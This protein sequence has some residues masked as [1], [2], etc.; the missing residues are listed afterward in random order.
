MSTFRKD[1]GGLRAISVL[2][3]LLFHFK[4]PGF[5][6]G[7]VGVDVFFVISGYLMTQIIVGRMKEEKF[8][9]LGF[10]RARALRILP[11]LYLMLIALLVSGFFFMAPLD[12]RS[13][14][15]SATSAALFVSNIL[16]WG[17][18]GYFQGGSEENWLLHTWSLSVEWQFYMLYPIALL[19]ACKVGLKSRLPAAIAAALLLSWGVAIFLGGA[20]PSIGFFSLPSRCWELLAGG[21]CIYA[22][23]LQGLSARVTQALG[24]IIIACCVCLYR[25]F[26]SYPGFWAALPVTGACL[27]LCVRHDN[28]LLSNPLSQ[29]IGDISYS[30]YLWHWP[31]VAAARYF[32]IDVSG[33]NIAWLF[34]ASFVL[35]QGSYSLVERNMKGKTV[36]RLQVSTAS[37]LA[38]AA[39]LVIS[40]GQVIQLKE[41][42]LSR[43]PPQYRSLL[44]ENEILSS[45]WKYP[46]ECQTNF[47]KSFRNPDV[48]LKVCTFPKMRD[49]GLLFWGDSLIEQLYPAVMEIAANSSESTGFKMVTSGGCLPVRRLNRTSE[50]YYCHEFNERVFQMALKKGARPV[51]V[52]LGGSWLRQLLGSQGVGPFVCEV[53][54]TSCREFSSREDAMAFVHDQLIRDIRE[55]K[56]A[57]VEVVIVLPF[58]VQPVDVAK[59]L[60][61]RLFLGLEERILVR[62]E[63]FENMSRPVTSMLIDVAKKTGASLWDPAEVLCSDIDCAGEEGFVARYRDRYHITSNT[64]LDLT[65][66]LAEVTR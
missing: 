42:M 64:V 31:V 10:F 34:L 30:L 9:L 14:A 12:Y 33:W 49:D 62:R 24:L 29:W 23:S 54:D 16:F 47:Q 3:V 56:A 51:K 38:S 4:V 28:Y 7:F 58:P 18:A 11:A 46:A 61:R 15:T 45:D 27:V 17:Q 13:L 60:S 65:P 43:T 48:E 20:R 1:I 19:I 66:A 55:L 50:G 2:A 22:P 53:E 40:M 41:G 52:V 26:P 35:A 57:E 44:Q 63:E 32:E 25:D 21:L 39:A 8:S 59:H 5:S 36:G 37:I 6:G